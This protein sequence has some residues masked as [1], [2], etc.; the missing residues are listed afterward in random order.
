LTINIPTNLYLYSTSHCHLCE[1]AHALILQVL[2]TPK[3]K[4]VE[5]SN[6]EQLLACYGLK[7]PV[8]QRQDTL[9]EL[10]WPF[11]KADVAEFIK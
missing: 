10:N 1:N 2:K 11:S 6:D 7:I 9:A 8:L 3:L 4:I 5:I